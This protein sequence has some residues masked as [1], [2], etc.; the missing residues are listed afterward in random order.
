MGGG[1]KKAKKGEKKTMQQ[2]YWLEDRQR[3]LV[4][5]MR[6][7]VFGNLLQNLAQS[8]LNINK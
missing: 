1:K 8:I 5:G 3:F 7:T 6:F 4:K 2:S